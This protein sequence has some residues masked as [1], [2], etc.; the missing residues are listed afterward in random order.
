MSLFNFIF[1]FNCLPLSLSIFRLPSF[2]TNLSKNKIK[3]RKSTV[4]EHN[5]CKFQYE[6]RT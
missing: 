3:K 5:M 2:C 6:K 1:H 4:D